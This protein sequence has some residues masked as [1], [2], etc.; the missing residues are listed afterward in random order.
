MLQTN[1]N[2]DEEKLRREAKII[3]QRHFSFMPF[4]FYFKVIKIRMR[5]FVNLSPEGKKV[6]LDQQDKIM[7]ITLNNLQR[8][9]K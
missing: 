5:M 8:T 2:I 6:F 1:K 9:K 7:N 4:E 3:W